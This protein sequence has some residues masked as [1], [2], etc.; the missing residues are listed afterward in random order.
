MPESCPNP[1]ELKK[2]RNGAWL[3]S[4]ACAALFYSALAC[5][6]YLLLGRI[7]FCPIRMLFGIPCMGCGLTHS[8]LCLLQGH[9]RESFNYCPLTVFVLL[10]MASAMLLHFNLCKLPPEL[11]AATRFFAMNRMWHAVLLLAFAVLYAVRMILYF[12]NGPY[13]MLYDERNCLRLL[14][15]LTGNRYGSAGCAGCAGKR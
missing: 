5:F 10:S 2:R 6:N 7:E 9:F 12:P 15:D 11:L 4:L 3:V 13:P 1:I 14:L 8:A